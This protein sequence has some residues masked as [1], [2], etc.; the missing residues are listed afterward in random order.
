MQFRLRIVV[1][2]YYCFF[3]VTAPIP[4]PEDK[5]YWSKLP[6]VIK[7]KKKKNQ[8]FIGLSITTREVCFITGVLVKMDLIIENFERT[9]IESSHQIKVSIRRLDVV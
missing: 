1:I 7:F 4:Y 6:K 9:G 8:S 5:V 3:P 2:Y